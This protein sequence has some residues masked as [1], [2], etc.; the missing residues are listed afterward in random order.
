MW[1]TAADKS[2]SYAENVF[3]IN[4]RKDGIA[5]ELLCPVK[6]IRDRGD[7]L[8]CPTL[9]VRL[10]AA[11]D[12][13]ISVETTHWAGQRKRG[14]N[15]DLFPDGPP[16]CNVSINKHD[17][18]TTLTSGS[19]AATVGPDP[20]AFD[21]K[22]H[23]ADGSKDLT[24]MLFRSVGFAYVPALGNMKQVEDMREVKHYVF[25]QTELSVGESIHGL[26][27]RFGGFNK[28]GQSV[29]IWNEDG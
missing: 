1:L 9:T 13:A 22:F 23:A 20:H 19:L 5:L 29:E 25:T 10:E 2:V 27:E 14:P 21:I 11:F 28:V 15:F 17:K 8:N 24:S 12:G 7:T 18:G 26:G 4:E 3:S 6:R 16:K